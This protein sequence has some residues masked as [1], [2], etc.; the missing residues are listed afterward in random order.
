MEM[1]RFIFD[2]SKSTSHQSRDYS[3]GSTELPVFY[4]EPSGSLPNHTGIAYL[5]IL[6][7]S[8]SLHQQ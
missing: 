7:P 4:M 1:I 2:V 5:P 6:L 3:K 8:I